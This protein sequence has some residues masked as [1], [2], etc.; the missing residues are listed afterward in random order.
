MA[1]RCALLQAV[2]KQSKD[3]RRTGMVRLFLVQEISGNGS[4][5]RDLAVEVVLFPADKLFL[6]FI[7]EW[8]MINK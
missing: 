3:E 8:T 4:A 1:C 5:L 7:E 2:M 6:K